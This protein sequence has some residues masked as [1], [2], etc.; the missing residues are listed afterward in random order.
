MR[1]IVFISAAAN[2][3][4]KKRTPTEETKIH[5]KL[6]KNNKQRQT[7]KKQKKKNTHNMED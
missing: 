3:A 1:V 6:K 4:I 7:K 2:A 5:D